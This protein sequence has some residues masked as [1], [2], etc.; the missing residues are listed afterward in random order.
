LKPGC[1]A[2]GDSRM[3][4]ELEVLETRRIADLALDARKVRDQ[5]L[6]KVPEADLGEPVPARGEHNLTG[7]IGLIEVLGSQPAVLALQQA[8]MALPRDI[9]EK[10]WALACA[11]RGDVGID[12]WEETVASAVLRTDD[13]ITADLV[14]EPDLHEHLRKGLYMLGATSVPGDG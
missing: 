8:I 10:V 14:G 4:Y 3:L 6:E 9:R 11:G 2:N 12:D 5:L 1:A 7:S 13:D